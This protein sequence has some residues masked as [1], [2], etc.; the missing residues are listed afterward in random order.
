MAPIGHTPSGHRGTRESYSNS[1]SNWLDAYGHREYQSWRDENPT[2]QV[3]YDEWKTSNHANGLSLYYATLR[4]FE[5][6]DSSDDG[7][8]ELVPSK[9]RSRAVR[10]QP[11]REPKKATPNGNAPSRAD[12]SA[13]PLAIAISEELNASSKRKRKARKKFLSEEIVA[14]E[15]DSDLDDLEMSA[16]ATGNGSPLTLGQSENGRRKSSGRKPRKKP[17]SQEIIS[18]EDELDDPMVIEDAL[19]FTAIQSPLPVRSSSKVLPI[20]QSSEIPKKT[21]LRLSTKKQ[22]KKKILSEPIVR[23]DDSD[24][25][26]V[27]GQLPSG[28]YTAESKAKIDR[29]SNHSSGRSAAADPASTNAAISPDPEPTPTSATRR[30][31]RTRRPAQ[32]RPYFHDAQLF[33]VVEPVPIEAIHDSLDAQSRRAS[34]NSIGQ[35]DEEHEGHEELAEDLGEESIA[36]LQDD[37]ELEPS[38]RKQK[39]FKGKGRAWKKEE[40]DEDEEFTLAKKKA[41][42]VAKAKLKGQV[43]IPKKRGRPR[44]ST[45]SEDLVRDESDSDAAKV[46]KASTTDPILHTTPRKVQARS[47]KSG[48]SEEFIREDSDSTHEGKDEDEPKT[49]NP[50]IEATPIMPKKRGRPRKSDQSKA[51]IPSV[52]KDVNGQSKSVHALPDVSNATTAKP[53]DSE[54]LPSQENEKKDISRNINNVQVTQKDVSSEE[55]IQALST[56]M[57]DG[58]ISKIQG[59]KTHPDKVDV[60]DSSVHRHDETAELLKAGKSPRLDGCQEDAQDPIQHR[61][62]LDSTKGNKASAQDATTDEVTASRS[63]PHEANAQTLIAKDETAKGIEKNQEP[64]EVDAIKNIEVSNAVEESTRSSG[65]MD[66]GKQSRLYGQ[67]E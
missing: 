53:A 23:D 61:I 10:S 58:N 60:Q 11:A 56:S 63:S 21:I 54:T 31:L 38:E 46:A 5:E 30:G 37:A 20:A 2:Q 44:K 22:P 50:T 18:P 9:G 48:L 25:A 26:L 15:G 33:D 55:L 28:I 65:D 39:H 16:P 17:I 42:K 3:S 40:S 51:H 27:P 12:G 34:T 45:L 13:T 52:H 35:A 29:D 59:Q 7:E 62:D 41:A 47:R 4:I 66:V 14:S 24:N 6:S 8:A 64:P 19:P 67:R 43:S 49:N 1:P 57:E 32:K 36:L